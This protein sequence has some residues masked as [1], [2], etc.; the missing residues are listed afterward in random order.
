MPI[1]DSPTGDSDQTPTRGHKKK[2][3]TRQQLIDAALVIYARKGA[4]ELTML[5][6][7]NE[8]GVANGTI[9]NY[10][11]T[12]EEVLEA[13]GLAMAEQLSHRIAHLNHGI[14]RGFLRLCMGIRVFICEAIA[15]PEWASA[16]VN[17][18][19]YDE[20]IKSALGGYVRGDMSDALKQGDLNY[21][22]EEL[23]LSYVVFGAAGA[24]LNIA[25]G[26]VAEDHDCLV[27]EMLLL[28]LGAAPEA[29]HAAAFM[30]L[31]R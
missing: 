21:R 2:A 22:N 12:R 16:V 14:E 5:E 11:R 3:R 15:N 1:N 23:A 20:G 18:V 25:E 30:P 29:A 13:V 10:F 31:K 26:L 9:Y 4:G 17:V 7:A 27:A 24:M 19:R 6:L 28:G 8:A